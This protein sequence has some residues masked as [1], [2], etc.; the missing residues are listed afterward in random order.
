MQVEGFGY[1]SGSFGE[2]YAITLDGL[3]YLFV[4]EESRRG[5]YEFSGLR[6]LGAYSTMEYDTIVH[7]RQLMKAYNP[8]NGKPFR[9]GYVERDRENGVSRII[10]MGTGRR[11]PLERTTVMRLVTGELD[12]VSAL[13]RSTPEETNKILRAL[14]IYNERHPLLLPL[15]QANR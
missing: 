6:I 11:L 10:E 13:E 4:R 3:P 14:V 12:L 1:K 15:P 5:F 8:V 2:P 7:T 9:E